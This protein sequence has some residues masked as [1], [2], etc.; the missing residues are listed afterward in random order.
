M[1]LCILLLSLLPLLQLPLL[2]AC[3]CCSPATVPASAYCFERFDLL[4]HVVMVARGRTRMHSFLWLMLLLWVPMLPLLLLQLLQ[5]VH[6]HSPVI[7]LAT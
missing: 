4:R 1:L 3:H 5:A 6:C 2:Q 7:V